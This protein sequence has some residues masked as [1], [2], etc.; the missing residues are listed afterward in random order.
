MPIIFFANKKD[1]PTALAP[2][3]I[4]QAL[5]LEAIKDRAWQIVPS[6][7]LSGEGLDKGTDWLAE[8]LA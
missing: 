8:K 2:A 6:N 4:A 3:E 5:Q 7:G 1:L